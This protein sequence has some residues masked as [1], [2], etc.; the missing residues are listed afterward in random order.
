MLIDTHCHLNLGPYQDDYRDIIREALERGVA[1]NNVG[2]DYQTSVRAVQIADE[3]ADKMIWASVGQHPTDTDQPFN[4]QKFRALASSS[5]KVIAIGETGL[6]YFHLD[7]AG[8][9][10]Y[11]K[12][13]QK[14]LFLEHAELAHELN[15]PIIIHCRDA[16]DDMIELLMHVYTTASVH[17]PRPL[18]DR[19][20]MHCF[21][22]T[23]LQ[24]Q[25]YIDLGFLI[26][27]P[28]IITFTDQYDDVVK[29]VPS[30]HFVVETDAP[31]LTPKPYRGQRNLPYYVEYT[32]RRVAELR[33]MTI[34]EVAETSTANAKRLFKIDKTR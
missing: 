9:V 10:E 1:I 28:G 7:K 11:Q 8:D 30:D 6:D 21:T 18:K 32:A 24:A 29:M 16:H 31:F 25:S 12:Q 20:V 15:L 13:Q 23:A 33:D 19:G 17:G 14:L 27:F 3:Y 34:D 26:S 4:L 5:E 22:G 2:C